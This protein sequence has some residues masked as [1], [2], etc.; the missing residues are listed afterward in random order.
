MN[1]DAIEADTDTAC[2]V[3]RSCH[4]TMVK[5]ASFGTH[6]RSD[7]KLNENCWFSVCYSLDQKASLKTLLRNIYCSATVRKAQ[8]HSF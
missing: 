7:L 1:G 6:D 5:I 3:H 4:C 8:S 2:V